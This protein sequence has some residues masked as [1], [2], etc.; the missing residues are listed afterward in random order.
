MAQATD[1]ATDRSNISEVLKSRADDCNKNDATFLF[2]HV[3]V[4]GFTSSPKCDPTCSTIDFLQAVMLRRKIW[5]F[6][7]VETHLQRDVKP[8]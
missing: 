1:K 3:N 6:S 2:G 8:S 5:L 4:D 7:I